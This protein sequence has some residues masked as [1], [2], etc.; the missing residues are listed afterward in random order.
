ML[1]LGGPPFGD[2][3]VKLVR[4]FPFLVLVIVLLALP[5][6]AQEIAPGAPG[7]EQ[8]SFAGMLFRMSFMF[9]L[10]YMIFHFL[11]IKPQKAK[12]SQQQTIISSLKRGDTV[13]TTGG[14]YARVAGIEKEHILLELA[15]NVKVKFELSAIAKRA[16]NA[17]TSGAQD[18]SAA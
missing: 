16:E 5:A 12:L 6:F 4:I 15:S 11:V 9:I 2:N 13:I 14:M 18:K 10:V 1:S 7:A 3:P 8:P 17:A